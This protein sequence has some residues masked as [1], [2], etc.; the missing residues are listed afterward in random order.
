MAFEGWRGFAGWNQDDR[1][2]ALTHLN[3]G[4]LQRE[5][6]RTGYRMMGKPP[7]DELAASAEQ[8]AAIINQY[9]SR[10]PTPQDFF[11]PEIMQFAWRPAIPPGIVSASATVSN[12]SDIG[13]TS[14]NR[15]QPDSQLTSPPHLTEDEL[16][17]DPR[18]LNAWRMVNEAGVKNAQSM[19]SS[20]LTA[21]AQQRMPE[22]LR[23]Q[24]NLREVARIN[25]VQDRDRLTMD[26]QN[27]REI[28]QR[29]Y[30]F[31]DGFTDSLDAGPII[32]R[33]DG[34]QP[35]RQV[36]RVGGLLGT[37]LALRETLPPISRVGAGLL[38]EVGIA[39][40]DGYLREKTFEENRSR[41]LRAQR[42][43]TAITTNSL[44]GWQNKFSLAEAELARLAA[45][46][47]YSAA[48]F[49]PN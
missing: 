37:L 6:L 44:D 2:I 42:S 16:R 40:I 34:E 21:F 15:L 39:G 31:W 33:N 3:A 46:H 5:R 45:E 28:K 30:S 10:R 26:Q 12:A 19:S 35:E 24:Y 32:E 38:G 22:A 41:D 49:K 17:L 4:A 36:P 27:E 13:E 14:A 29:G 1:N 9:N 11:T 8:D 20:E 7:R 25:I 23:N 18:L 48:W 43:P 47:G